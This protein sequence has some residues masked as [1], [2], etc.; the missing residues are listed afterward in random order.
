MKDKTDTIYG[1]VFVLEIKSSN[2]EKSYQWLRNERFTSFGT[3]L[4][5]H[6]V[7]AADIKCGRQN[8]AS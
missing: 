3:K 7:G 5:L 8:I 6:R 2:L 1:K 4:W